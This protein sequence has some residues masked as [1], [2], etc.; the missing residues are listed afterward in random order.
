MTTKPAPTGGIVVG[1]DGSPAS[2][3]AVMW[4]ADEAALQHRPL[5]LVHARARIPAEQRAWLASAGIPSRQV[6]DRIQRDAEHVVERARELA[7]DRCP[8]DSIETVV[9]DQDARSLLLDLGSTASMTV[10]GTRGHGSVASLLLGSV[11]AE[12]VD[13]APCP[14][15]VA[16]TGPITG[17]VLAVDGSEAADAA[18]SVVSTWPIFADLPVHVVSVTVGMEPVEFGAAPPAYHKAAAD[19][20]AA[21]AEE[22]QD[23]TRMATDAA[24]RLRAAGLQADPTMRTSPDSAATEIVRFAAE[25]GSELI[26][27]G[28]R[29][30]TGIARLAL[31]SVARNVLYGSPTSVLIVRP[32]PRASALGGVG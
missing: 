17:L 8:P 30:R 24:A 5:T 28:S 31:G 4:A 32:Q 29:G 27:M 10:V 14:V 26:V 18:E 7:A 21:Y 11:S 9:A 23:H 22:L 12:V 20:A 16:R 19:H 6:D 25:T 13:N 2:E 15:L 1:V 3:H